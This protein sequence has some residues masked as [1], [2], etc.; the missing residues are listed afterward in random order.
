M[1]GGRRLALGEHGG[2]APLGVPAVFGVHAHQ[3]PRLA[4]G[5]QGAAERRRVDHQPVRIR[6]V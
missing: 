2:R 3:D 5:A 4:R 6:E 1:A